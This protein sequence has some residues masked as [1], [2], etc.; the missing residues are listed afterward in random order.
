MRTP[1]ASI[2]LFFLCSFALSAQSVYRQQVESIAWQDL[3]DE[4]P[5]PN[6]P[7]KLLRAADAYAL[8]SS[9]GKLRNTA[10]TE[11]TVLFEL[12]GGMT[13]YQRKQPLN[14]HL[15]ARTSNLFPP[16]AQ[17]LFL[18]SKTRIPL[19]IKSELIVALRPQIDPR[20]YF[21]ADWANVRQVIGAQ[22]QFLLTL[23]NFPAEAVLETVKARQKDNRVRW[24]EPNFAYK[25]I[26]HGFRGLPNDALFN[27]E[28]HLQNSG[29]LGGK[30]GQDINILNAWQATIGNSNIVVAIFDGGIQINHPDLEKNIFVNAND[31]PN[32]IDDDHNGYVDDVHGWDYYG[33]D[34]LPDPDP[35]DPHGTACAG[36]IAATLNNAIGVVGAAPGIRI[37]PLRYG[38]STVADAQAIYYAA[39]LSGSQKSSWKGADIISFSLSMEESIAVSDA[40]ASA[41]T[42]GRSHK[43]VLMFASSGNDAAAWYEARYPRPALR[44][45]THTIRFEFENNDSPFYGPAFI[46][47]D[48]FRF[49]GDNLESFELGLG[50]E[51][52]TGGTEGPWKLVQDGIENQHALTGWDGSGAHALASG[53]I[54]SGGKAWIQVTKLI[55]VDNEMSFYYWIDA[56][57]P[58]RRF[59]R[60]NVSVDGNLIRPI[61]LPVSTVVTPLLNNNFPANHRDV[62]AVGGSTDRGFRADYSQYGD[63]LDFVAPTGGGL[64]GIPTTDL[65]GDKGYSK[66]DYFLDFDGTSASAPIAAAVAALVLSTNPDLSAAE[67]KGIMRSSCAKI[68]DV[69]YIDGR[70]QYYGYG[71]VNAAEAILLARPYSPTIMLAATNIDAMVGQTLSILATVGTIEKYSVTWRLNGVP[72]NIPSASSNTLVLNNIAPTDAGTYTVEVRTNSGRTASA[73]VTVNVSVTA[74]KGI[75]SL[76]GIEG[77]AQAGESIYPANSPLAD[78]TIEAWIYPTT[79]PT[80]AYLLRD[81]A[82]QTFYQT[83]FISG[84][85]QYTLFYGDASSPKKCVFDWDDGI[86]VNTWSHVAFMFDRASNTMISTFNGKIQQL[87]CLLSSTDFPV[88]RLPFTIGGY[89]PGLEFPPPGIFKGY[90]DEVR[91]S[92]VV[93]YPTNFIPERRFVPDEATVALYHFDEPAGSTRFEDSSGNGHFLLSYHGATIPPGSVNPSVRLNSGVSDRVFHIAIPTSKG[94]DYVIQRSG[95]LDHSRWEDVKLVQGSGLA[96]DFVDNASNHLEFYRVLVTDSGP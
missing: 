88:N 17:P 69:P 2:F 39:G 70:N 65:V 61:V 83:G 93:R 1:F 19:V 16:G 42:N 3:G 82:Y 67:V 21:G 20:D 66:D 32:G 60:L 57:H 10:A 46:W 62:M 12:P 8:A 54:P 37:L 79:M 73:S 27:R 87:T 91:I 15:S 68:G 78:F 30:I 84:G 25:P 64:F 94:W 75:L 7:K 11:D 13:V 56:A 35:S 59:V 31:P 28:W 72:L 45:T 58:E 48:G 90:V 53:P 95:G 34:N 18:N 76:D 43:G 55:G 29:K 49:R 22:S 6:G 89:L 4:C 96:Y 92:S 74:G 44:Y 5:G 52:E 50:P 24:V 38:N 51:W 36:L 9:Y 40:L 14:S 71:Q 47:L 63:K 33:G 80:W 23:T 85:D 81:S 86:S 77:Y 26:S 41:A